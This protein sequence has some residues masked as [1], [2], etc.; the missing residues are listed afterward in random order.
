MLDRQFSRERLALGGAWVV[1]LAGTA[2]SLYYGSVLG[3]SP[4][5]LCWFQRAAMYPL[6]VVLWVA[7]RRR[8]PVGRLALPLSL[9]GAALAAYHSWVQ[10]SARG[11]CSVG[12]CGTV[13]HRTLGLTIPNQALLAFAAIS[14]AVA[15]V[16]VRRDAL[17]APRTDH[18]R[19]ATSR[20][21]DD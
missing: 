9:S 14:L 2:G 20:A 15:A 7:L 12:G 19:Q 8:V 11:T 5:R 16:A 1:A 18:S 3:L 13:Q 17:A 6:V 21:G 4:C 10:A